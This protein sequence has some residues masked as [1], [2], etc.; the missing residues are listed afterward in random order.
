MLESKKPHP[1]PLAKM[2]SA[3]FPLWHHLF[4]L[5]AHAAFTLGSS[6]RVQ[7][8]RNMPA[9]GP[10]LLVANHQSFFDPPMVGLAAKRPLVYLARK[11]LFR[12][13]FFAGLI[14]SLNA[15]PIDQEGV[16]KEGIRTILEQLQLG[17]PVLVFPEGERTRTGSLLPLKPG[18]HLLIKRVHAPIIPVGIAGAFDAWP[19]TCL[20]PMPAPLW[21]PTMPGTLSISLGKP[22]AAAKFHGMPREEVLTELS[23]LIRAEQER[24]EQLRRK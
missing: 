24:A 15:V 10:A 11:T 23:N 6:L 12:N 17:K 3:W 20:L 14:R 19:R 21:L 16:G 8:T 4:Y 7:G 2:E 9:E 13:R 22:V 1:D 5:S 18:I